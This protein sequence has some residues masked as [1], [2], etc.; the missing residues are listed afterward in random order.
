MS[1]FSYRCFDVLVS[2]AEILSK[3]AGA[4]QTLSSGNKQS[5]HF[6]WQATEDL[7]AAAS[8]FDSLSMPSM[9]QT[10]IYTAVHGPQHSSYEKSD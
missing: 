4:P 2:A 8:Q 10:G 7:A 3:A 1:K 5:M 9:M 6:L